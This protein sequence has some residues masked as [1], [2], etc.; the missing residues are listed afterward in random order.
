M[1]GFA[2]DEGSEKA[3]FEGKNEKNGKKYK[4]MLY[5]IKKGLVSAKI[6]STFAAVILKTI[7]LP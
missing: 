7:F 2:P 4:N 3:I 6:S 5:N 1:A